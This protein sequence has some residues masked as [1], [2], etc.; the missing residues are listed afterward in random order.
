VH[1][2]IPKPRKA[3]E[4]DGL[5]AF[6]KSPE[7]RQ[8]DRLIL[9]M[10]VDVAI[11]LSSPTGRIIPDTKGRDEKD[12][13][14]PHLQLAR[15]IG[16]RTHRLAGEGEVDVEWR[17]MPLPKPPWD[18]QNP[19]AS[20]SGWEAGDEEAY[21]HGGMGG[22]SDSRDGFV[23][24]GIPHP[25]LLSMEQY[26]EAVNRT[27][28]TLMAGGVNGQKRLILDGNK[29]AFPEVSAEEMKTLTLGCLLTKCG[30]T[31]GSRQPRQ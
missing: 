16:L 5:G 21:L 3:P 24:L 17:R 28:R 15:E 29:A 7:V 11:F 14:R 18:P 20:R 9:E 12:A 8:L 13:Q 19:S 22:V 25:H 6:E 27:A 23:S 1:K 10:K 4:L 31:G 30:A 26:R 2:R